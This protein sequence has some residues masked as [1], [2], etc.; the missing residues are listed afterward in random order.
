MAAAS[1][2]VVVIASALRRHCAGHVVCSLSASCVYRCCVFFSFPVPLPK[3]E[4][5]TSGRVAHSEGI[6]L[7]SAATPEHTDSSPP[8]RQPPARSTRQKHGQL[9]TSAAEEE[10]SA[11]RRLCAARLSFAPRRSSPP[12]PPLA[13]SRLSRALRGLGG[14]C[15][16]ECM[17]R[18]VRCACGDA[19]ACPDLRARLA[20]CVRIFFAFSD[21]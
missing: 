8:T 13:R 1:L 11:A 2:L 21:L 15:Q 9:R 5:F 17:C 19:T 12:A 3:H 16:L 7:E 14:A 4:A 6:I 18:C 10:V 20:I